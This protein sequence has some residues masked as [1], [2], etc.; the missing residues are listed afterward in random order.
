MRGTRLSCHIP[1]TTWICRPRRPLAALAELA[2]TDA[3]S[4]LKSSPYPRNRRLLPQ[5]RRGQ[6]QAGA[7]RATTMKLPPG[8]A[9]GDFLSQNCLGEAAG[10]YARQ[11]F[12]QGC[13]AATGRASALIPRAE[14]LPTASHPQPHATSPAGAAPAQPASPGTGGPGGR[15]QFQLK[16]LIGGCP[17][18]FSSSWLRVLRRR[19]ELWVASWCGRGSR[20]AGARSGCCGCTG[21]A[22]LGRGLCEPCSGVAGAGPGLVPWRRCGP[23]D[24]IGGKRRAQVRDMA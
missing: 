8:T 4:S 14:F 21:G 9:P 12:E 20:T 2:G 15:L 6:N 3:S 17:Y 10:F 22:G 16:Q 24:C 19:T 23:G 5:P 7:F 18:V 1:P 11:Y 13:P